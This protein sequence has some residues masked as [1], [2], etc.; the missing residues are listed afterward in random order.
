[1]QDIALQEESHS[2]PSQTCLSLRLVLMN[3][4][5]G[6]SPPGSSRC[7]RVL[8]EDAGRG[9]T[10]ANRAVDEWLRQAIAGVHER[11]VTGEMIDSCPDQGT[12]VPLSGGGI[13]P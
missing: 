1:M 9:A 10:A 7:L 12:E 5:G 11:R 8:S 6:S 13:N 2:T 4:P 3:L